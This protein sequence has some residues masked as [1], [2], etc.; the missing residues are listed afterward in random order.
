MLS[1][2][3]LR[4]SVCRGKQLSEFAG[5]APSGKQVRIPC[6]VVYELANKRITQACI[7]FETE[8]LRQLSG[9]A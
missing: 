1:L 9:S 6:C 3:I 5:I 7:Y 4:G 2:Y 8:V